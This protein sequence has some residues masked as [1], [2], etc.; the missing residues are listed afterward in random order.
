MK[1]R[2][3]LFSLAFVLLLLPLLANHAVAKPFY[4]GKTIRLIVATNPGGG[5]D[6][7]GRLAAR[8][9]QK[10]LPGSTIIVKN[11]PG[12]GHIIG[13]NEVYHAKP[14]GLTFGT[15]N[16]ALP[17]AQVAGLKG[18]KFDLAKMT[19][20]G[21]AS[22]EIYSLVTTKKFRNVED[23]RKAEEVKFSSAGIGSLSHVAAE[24]F[25]EMTGIRNIKLIT[26][27]GGGEAELAMMRG[28]LDGQFGSWN[29]MGQPFVEEGHGVPLIF[30]SKEKPK[31]YEEVPL[32]QELVTEKE[33]EPVVSFLTTINLLGRPF[34]A[35]PDMP[36][37][38]AK[39]LQDAFAKACGDE[40]LLKIAQ[41]SENPIVY[42]DG[43]E[44]LKMVQSLLHLPPQ[45][46]KLI[47][48]AYGVE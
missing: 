44:A 33:Y 15:F 38:R 48:E 6:F 45:V 36:E 24:L 23:L 10:H 18:I 5:Y 8:F 22:S 13:C 7:Y 21:S 34:A 46:V 39:I 47:K 3:V 16:R 42:T 11:V 4:E 19:W 41:K 25:K 29:T 20:L 9:M 37:D 32:L 26:G 30:I 28:E 35:P 12:A 31:G 27:Y 40:E 1:K 43:D 2:I 17:L 14:D